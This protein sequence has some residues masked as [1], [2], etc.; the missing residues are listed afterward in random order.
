MA[1]PVDGS[2]VS[3]VRPSAA[4]GRSPPIT[5]RWGP[6]ANERAAS[7]RA[8]GSV[9]VVLMPLML[10]K[11]ELHAPQPVELEADGVALLRLMGRSEH[12]RDDPL[13]APQLLAG[14]L[15]AGGHR[16]DHPLQALRLHRVLLL[17]VHEDA[18][19]ARV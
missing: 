15:Q 14:R 12:A 19:R 1:R 4:S 17:A 3:N 9:A 10:R 5:N 2:I 18:P 13:P 11:A 8:P 7:E 16:L 6:E